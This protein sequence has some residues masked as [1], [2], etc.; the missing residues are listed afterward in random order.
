M[1]ANA[2]ELKQYIVQN[3]TEVTDSRIDD[4]HW[5]LFCTRCNITRGFQVIKRELCGV[6]SKRYHPPRHSDNFEQDF[7]AP[8]TVLFRCPVCHAF[9]QWILY[10]ID[11]VIPPNDIKS[12]YFQVTSIPGEGLEQIDELPQN[13]PS[14]RDAY[15]QAIRAMDANA[16][17]AA[18]A[19]FR[20]ALQVITRDLLGAKP[21]NLANELNAVV[22]ASYN[23]VVVTKNFANV[24]YIIKEAGNQGAHPDKDPDLLTFTS[25]DAQDLQDIFME[26]V[27]DLFIIPAV[28][29]KAR[30]D[31]LAR[32]KIVAKP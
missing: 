25:Q 28:K 6:W 10:K 21:G 18:A 1:F 2:N 11:E 15:R 24:G 22:G 5:D 8:F 30:V 16:H 31:F 19:M 3:Y 7:D 20:R 27:G 9:K 14:L 12:Q 13:P 32:R 26:L 4:D 17:L 23:G 29:E